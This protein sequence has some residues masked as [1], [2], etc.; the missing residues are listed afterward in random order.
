MKKILV[1]FFCLLGFAVFAQEALF[2]DKLIFEKESTMEDLVTLYSYLINDKFSDNLKNYDANLK[3]LKD[4]FKYF[5]KETS[6]TK[7]VTVGDFSLLTIQYLKIESGL[8]YLATRNGRYATREL[9]SRNIIPFNTS[10]YDYISGLDL[11][12]YLQKVV[13]YEETLKN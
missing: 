6:P 4:K 2:M 3:Y 5:P 13:S 10:E 7:K 9:L 1:M 12:S 8:F 11:V